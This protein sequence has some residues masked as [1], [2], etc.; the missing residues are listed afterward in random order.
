MKRNLQT[1]NEEIKFNENEE[2][3]S[4]TDLRGVITYA[5]EAFIRVSGFSKDEL[6]GHNHNIVRHPDMPAQAF[7]DLWEKLKNARSWRGIVK[8]RRKDGRYYWV[9]AY[10]TPIF[11]NGEIV[12]YQ[13]VRTRPEE[14]YKSKAIQLYSKL[15][16][17]KR[18]EPFMPSFSSKL[19]L[20]A[21]LL[22]A[23]FIYLFM[24]AGIAVAFT[25]L[26]PIAFLLWLFSHELWTIPAEAEKIKTDYDSVSRYIY[27]G[28][29]SHSFFEFSQLLLKAK[30]RT[31]IGRFA[32]L[33]GNLNLVS[34]RLSES[35]SLAS[36]NSRKQK[37]EL[38]QVAT[39]VNEMSATAVDIAK[40]TSQTSEQVR[41]TH[42]LCSDATTQMNN[43]SSGMNTLSH[44]VKLAA[45]SAGELK[46]QAM[47]VQ[48]VMDEIT[49]IAEQTNLLALNA[50]IESARAGEQGRG[51]S[52]VADEVRALSSRTQQSA[53]SIK[54]SIESM[55]LTIEK[56]MV[57][58]Q[59]N[60]QQ[61]SDCNVAAMG[62]SKTV[63]EISN[64]VNQISDLSVQIATAAEQQG[65]VSEEINRNIQSIDLLSDENLVNA[66]TLEQD[67]EELLNMTDYIKDVS[68]TF[69]VNS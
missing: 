49:G 1:I 37:H 15:T 4:T 66:Q 65:S 17:G 21:I 18:I 42:Q 16:Q 8:N 24:V 25:S 52:V 47:K 10:V 22:F 9:D 56:W 60:Q 27:S 63:G 2:L 34:A 28:T 53:F 67:A 43:T 41:F 44:S 58:M 69:N 32:D 46:E 40:N 55:H 19:I 20:A 61:A 59:S 14:A 6:I 57:T 64:L 62:A 51:F 50:A 29:G 7:K 38:T 54:S 33:I 45:E 11:K 5:N 23:Q 31:V 48:K 26:I 3:V 30:N 39:A 12:G 68:Q 35:I 13:S 36:N